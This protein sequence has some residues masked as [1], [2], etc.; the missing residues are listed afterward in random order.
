M[1]DSVGSPHSI[2]LLNA[3]NAFHELNA[4]MTITTKKWSKDDRDHATVYEAILTWSAPHTDMQPV[5]FRAA[6][7]SKKD[8]KQQA[9]YALIKALGGMGVR[10]TKIAG[11]A[12]DH[13]LN[14]FAYHELTYRAGQSVD[15]AREYVTANDIDYAEES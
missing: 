15:R 9:A 3:L 10:T 14:E 12:S 6:A 7:R 13:L 8:A 5:S 4:T 11:G 2:C 1:G